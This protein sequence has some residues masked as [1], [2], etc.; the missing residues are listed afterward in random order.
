[1][2]YRLSGIFLILSS[3]IGFAG[4]AGALRKWDGYYL[5]TDHLI[6][7]LGISTCDQIR[8]AFGPRYICSPGHDWFNYGLVISGWFLVFA[9]IALIAA[10]RR[11][12][13]RDLV[14]GYLSVGI[15]LIVSGIS[16]S[17]VGLFPSDTGGTAHGSAAAVH[18]V[19]LWVAMIL[20]I[21]ASS[22]A[23]SQ[24][25]L[26][27]LHGTNRVLT[28]VFLG[29]SVLGFA[30]LMLLGRNHVMPGFFERLGFDVLSVW[31]ILLG[32]ALMAIPGLR[33]TEVRK[34]QQRVA[35]RATQKQ[36][37]DAVRKAVEN[38]DNN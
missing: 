29:V 11:A 33:T 12:E 17:S 14:A 21:R 37:D 32:A 9:G 23:R 34:K 38:L 31:T 2:L 25:S 20:G 6:S 36:R 22:A 18:A 10:G 7:D 4:Q 30:G 1:M 3:L 13:P 26:P 35:M 19:T 15:V 27:M 24:G 5:F 16:L 8:D 28:V